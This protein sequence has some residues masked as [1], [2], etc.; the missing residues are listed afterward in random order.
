MQLSGPSDDLRGRTIS[1]AASG[2]ET[3]RESSFVANSFVLTSVSQVGSA[4]ANKRMV[5]IR[6][7]VCESTRTESD[8]FTFANCG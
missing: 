5:Y 7:V 2:I 6:H 4:T 3:I 1:V 8:A